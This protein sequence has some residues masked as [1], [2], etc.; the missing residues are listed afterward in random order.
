MLLRKT[1]ERS[2]SETQKSFIECNLYINYKL[3]LSLSI[4][5]SHFIII[6]V[7]HP[8]EKEI[9]DESPK[10]EFHLWSVEEKEMFPI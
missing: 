5:N 6:F 7:L 2:S 1:N 4:L 9:F 8:F 3:F 10:K